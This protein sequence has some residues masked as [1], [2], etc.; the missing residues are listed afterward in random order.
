MADIPLTYTAVDTSSKTISPA[1]VEVTLEQ[2]TSSTTALSGRKQV[3]SFGSNAYTVKMIF[4]PLTQE[5]RLQLTALLASKRGGLTTLTVSPINLQTKKGSAATTADII[6]AES[7]IGDTTITLD[8]TTAGQYTPG[9]FINF[10]GHTKAYQVIQQ[11]G[12][13]LTIEPG[14]LKT[15]PASNT[16]KSGSDF[17]MT[18]RLSNELK[19]TQTTDNF[20]S[21]TLEFVE[22]Y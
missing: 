13:Q 15:V 8:A 7:A 16:I 1:T 2:P 4:P 21:I 3:R 19:F 22:S 10:S 9:E 11:S 5:D 20:S 14:V 17:Q 18:V 12:N 6:N